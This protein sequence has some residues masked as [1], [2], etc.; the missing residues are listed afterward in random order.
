MG[1]ADPSAGNYDDGNRAFLQSLMARGTVTFPEA[2]VVLA[3]IFTIQEGKP[4]SLAQ[5]A[6]DS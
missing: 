4:L 6:E 5:H 3:E 1:D 2:Q